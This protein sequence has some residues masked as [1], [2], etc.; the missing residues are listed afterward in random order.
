MLFFQLDNAW[1]PDEMRILDYDGSP[2][3]APW[4]SCP[5]RFGVYQ[6]PTNALVKQTIQ[7]FLHSAKNLEFHVY[8]Y[9][10]GLHSFS[11]LHKVYILSSFSNQ[12]EC[13]FVPAYTIIVIRRGGSIG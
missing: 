2:I 8:Y 4:D 3:L 11:F 6:Q 5:N 7:E 10:D 13:D 12:L 1:V 9:K